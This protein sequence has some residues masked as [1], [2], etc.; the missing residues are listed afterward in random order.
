ME[1]QPE[2]FKNRIEQAIEEAKV[3]GGNMYMSQALNDVLVFYE[4]EAK[5]NG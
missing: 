4:D 2:H 1:I 5:K 3:Q